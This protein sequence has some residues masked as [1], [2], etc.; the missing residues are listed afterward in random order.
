M[1][2]YDLVYNGLLKSGLLADFSDFIEVVSTV[3]AITGDTITQ[4]V[5]IKYVFSETFTNRDFIKYNS[6]YVS[7]PVYLSLG[8]V[9]KGQKERNIGIRMKNFICTDDTFLFLPRDQLR[10]TFSSLPVD[11]FLLSITFDNKK[12]TI[13]N[14]EINLDRD[15]FIVGT[16]EGAIRVNKSLFEDLYAIAQKWYSVPRSKVKI[17]DP[18]TFF[19]KK[20]ILYGVNSFD[21]IMEYGLDDYVRENETLK[22]HRGTKLLKLV[23]FMLNKEVK[24]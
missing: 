19:S 13:F 11:P 3:C 17:K 10:Q 15:N 7:V 9:C 4:G 2:K 22:V 23:V 1:N 6:T 16:D 12:H 14:S 21:K 24:K 18:P 5:H 8:L 20:D